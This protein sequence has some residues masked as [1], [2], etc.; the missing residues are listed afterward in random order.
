MNIMNQL[1]EW[2]K[3]FMERDELLPIDYQEG[4]IVYPKNQPSGN[5]AIVLSIT[6]TGIYLQFLE[7]EKVMPKKFRVGHHEAHL[8]TKDKIGTILHGRKDT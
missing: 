1:A 4:D 8:L 5:R 7:T 3:S 6:E 2:L